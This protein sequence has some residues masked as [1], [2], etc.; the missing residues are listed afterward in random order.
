MVEDAVVANNEVEVAEVMVALVP[1]IEV[2]VPLVAV[3]VA[4]LKVVEVAFVVVAFAAVTLP[5]MVRLPAMVEEACET[6]P[7]GR[8]TV[9]VVVG[10][11]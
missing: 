6:K 9:M 8:R 7:D 11:R 4:A 10:A 1:R 3:S 5:A 2:M